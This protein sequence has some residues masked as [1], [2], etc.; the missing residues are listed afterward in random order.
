MSLIQTSYQ[1]LFPDKEFS[2][3]TEME[4]NRRLKDFNANIHLHKNKIKINLNLQWKD[5]DDEIKIGL[6]QHLLLKIFKKRTSTSN[7]NLYNNFIKNIP[8]LTLKTKIDPKLEQSFNRIN[9]L[10]LNNELE[11]PNLIWGQQAFRKLAHYN[12]HNDSIIVSETFK[13]TPRHVLDYLMYHEMLHKHFK[14][15]SKNGRLSYHNKEFRQAEAKYPNQKVV[16]AEITAIIRSK[17]KKT[18]RNL[19]RWI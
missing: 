19:W 15:S 5:I 13:D 4:Y 11:K 9:Q 16:E 6:I 1:R 3:E 14:F 10:L 12:F 7:I 2:Y 18:R 17:K 8:T